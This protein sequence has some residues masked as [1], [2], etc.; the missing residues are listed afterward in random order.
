MSR[1]M[2]VAGSRLEAGDGAGAV[3]DEPACAGS[4]YC[5]AVVVIESQVHTV[6]PLPTTTKSPFCP[7]DSR[8]TLPSCAQTRP[9][10]PVSRLDRP[11]G[12]CVPPSDSSDEPPS[13]PLLQATSPLTAVVPCALVATLFRR[14]ETVIGGR[15]EGL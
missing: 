4:V 1:E 7:C 12:V 11:P 13:R 2:A 9:E 3:V 14:S 15:V 10:P 5:V 6:A 8:R